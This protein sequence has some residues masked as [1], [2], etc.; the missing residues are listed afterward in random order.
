MLLNLYTRLLAVCLLGVILLV[1]NSIAQSENATKAEEPTEKKSDLKELNR[2]LAK[3]DE[4][5]ITWVDLYSR[6]GTLDDLINRKLILK[7]FGSLKME[8]SDDHIEQAVENFVKNQFNN[9]REKFVEQLNAQGI[10]FE[11]F[12]EIQEEQIALRAL[13]SVYLPKNVKSTVDERNQI[14]DQIKAEYKAGET[15][16]LQ[17]ITVAK[18][19]GENPKAIID[20]VYRDLLQFTT[21]SAYRD[22]K[23][24][25]EGLALLVKKFTELSKKVNEDRS[26][27]VIGPDGNEIKVSTLSDRVSAAVSEIEPG[28]FSAI[29]DDGIMW[30]IALLKYRNVPSPPPMDKIQDQVDA[31]V[32]KLKRKRYLDVFLRKVKNGTKIVIYE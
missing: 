10:S 2:V 6:G 13:E 25:P 14:Y 31:R 15:V 12:R 8:I 26:G 28:Q 7:A 24:K 1:N 9:D 18:D 30:K 11:R 3:V 27:E 22:L 21:S 32:N 19:S 20:N 5:T 4:E 16:K 23:G 29:F 17:V